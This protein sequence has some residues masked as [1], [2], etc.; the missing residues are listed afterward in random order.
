MTLLS[1]KISILQFDLA[2]TKI[3]EFTDLAVYTLSN[4]GTVYAVEP[5][6]V[7]GAPIVATLRY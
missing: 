3:Y 4:S 5:E 2:R 6:K 7:L 1:L